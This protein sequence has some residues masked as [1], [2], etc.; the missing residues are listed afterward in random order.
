MDAGRLFIVAVAALLTGYLIGAERRESADD[1]E[2]AQGWHQ[3]VHSALWVARQ[4]VSDGRCEQPRQ[5]R[6]GPVH[7]E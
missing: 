1:V 5:S 3:H 4:A 6:L 2:R 7:P